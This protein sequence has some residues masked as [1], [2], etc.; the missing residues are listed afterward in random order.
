MMASGAGS[1]SAVP[2]CLNSERTGCPVCVATASVSMMNRPGV[3]GDFNLC[4]GWSR[5]E[6]EEVPAGVA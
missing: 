6:F 1:K 5:V 3:S 4:E 2:G